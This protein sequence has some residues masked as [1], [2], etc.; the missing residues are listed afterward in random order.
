MH[1]PI[2]PRPTPPLPSFG[3]CRCRVNPTGRANSH[4][5]FMRLKRT[6][7]THKTSQQT[8]RHRAHLCQCQKR[9][10][11]T[12]FHTR[13]KNTNLRCPVLVRAHTLLM[14]NKAIIAGVDAALG[15]CLHFARNTRFKCKQ[16]F[17]NYL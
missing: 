3:R 14:Q 15:V 11:N 6:F 1:Q 17:Q 9:W 13:Y 5:I 7:T 16:T 12:Q 8:T 4:G 10:G 2:V